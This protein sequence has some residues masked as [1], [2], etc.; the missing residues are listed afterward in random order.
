MTAK[1]GGSLRGELEQMTVPFETVKA[2]ISGVQGWLRTVRQMEAAPVKEIAGLLGVLKR[3]ILRLEV[4]EESGRITLGRLREVAE[5]M[6]CELVYTFLPKETTFEELAQRVQRA[7]RE[8][9]QERLRNREQ[10]ELEKGRKGY[11]EVSVLTL[12][13]RAV[14][15]ELRRYGIS[16]R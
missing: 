1:S 8:T 13:A 2:Q 4:A 14:K 7:K 6:N 3:E 16:V 5:T 12:L 11:G 9:R 15:R 10:K